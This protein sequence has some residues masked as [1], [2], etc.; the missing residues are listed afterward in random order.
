MYVAKALSLVLFWGKTP[1]APYYAPNL[2][3]VLAAWV[4]RQP[5]F[6]GFFFF[7]AIFDA[8]ARKMRPKSAALN[9]CPMAG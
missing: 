6:A 5:A 2:Y 8:Q 7:A 1:F 9:F 4:L 3:R